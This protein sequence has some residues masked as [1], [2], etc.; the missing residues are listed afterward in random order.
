M[1]L[2]SSGEE[3][4]LGSPEEFGRLP[5]GGGSSAAEFFSGEPPG[6]RPVAH[7]LTSIIGPLDSIGCMP[8]CPGT[9]P[10]PTFPIPVTA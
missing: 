9:W 1:T 3:N 6:F 5:E 7:Q 4:K 10:P 2:N 8:V